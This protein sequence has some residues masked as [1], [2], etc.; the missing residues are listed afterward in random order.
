M[1]R[2]MALLFVIGCAAPHERA[3]PGPS[4]KKD[5]LPAGVRVVEV[6]GSDE[7]VYYYP[8]SGPIAAYAKGDR[9][10][11]LIEVRGRMTAE[12]NEELRNIGIRV[13]SL[14]MYTEQSFVARLDSEQRERVAALPFVWEVRLLQPD[15]K[16]EPS[17]F[18]AGEEGR[19][20]ITIDLLDVGDKKLATIGELLESLGIRV[21]E[22]GA[23]SIHASVSMSHL[24]EITRI[25]DVIWIEPR[26]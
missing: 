5:G 25:S 17:C 18:A 1:T 24:D 3:V 7:R 16:L 2:A 20:E 9:G 13:G 15:D 26:R 23:D 11:F 19:L 12:E 6:P 4:P 22:L 10:P 21:L 14:E 8:G